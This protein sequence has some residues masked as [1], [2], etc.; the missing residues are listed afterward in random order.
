MKKIKKV[1]FLED[2]SLRVQLESGQSY[3][4]N[5]K[6]KLKTVRFYDL[7]DWNIFSEG[8]IRNNQAICWDNGTEL[9]LDEIIS[10]GKHI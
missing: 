7:S 9:Y 10:D 5:M 4:Y 8:Y 2:F 3:V 6:P 1:V